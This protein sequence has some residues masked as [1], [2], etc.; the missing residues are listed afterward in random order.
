[1]LVCLRL[2]FA[3]GSLLQFFFEQE[4]WGKAPGNEENKLNKG[5]RVNLQ[6]PNKRLGVYKKGVGKDKVETAERKK[7]TR[8]QASSELIDEGFA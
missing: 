1:M 6:G 5:G 3:L 8:L 2:G 4:P 7:I